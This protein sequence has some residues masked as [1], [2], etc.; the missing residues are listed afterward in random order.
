MCKFTWSRKLNLPSLWALQ[1]PVPHHTDHSLP[2]VLGQGQ[3]QCTSHAHVHVQ[4]FNVYGFFLALALVLAYQE[5]HNTIYVVATCV[6][7]V[8]HLPG[9]VG[10]GSDALYPA[11]ELCVGRPFLPH[12][13]GLDCYVGTGWKQKSR[14]FN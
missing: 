2:L 11:L 5:L 12:N 8:H 13:A 7:S 10:S 14:R 6:L 3:P 4:H 9:D 1:T